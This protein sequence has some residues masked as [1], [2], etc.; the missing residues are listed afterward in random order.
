[1]LIYDL[2]HTIGGGLIRILRE[3]AWVE[4]I[5]TFQ[6]GVLFLGDPDHLTSEFR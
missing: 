3:S 5:E 6:R 4:G 1:M 2:E